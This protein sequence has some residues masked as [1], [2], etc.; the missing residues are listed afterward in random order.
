L[1]LGAATT[2]VEGAEASACWARQTKPLNETTQ[3]ATT[4]RIRKTN[5][6]A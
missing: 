1:P 3:S 2:G 6:N 5:L 4:L